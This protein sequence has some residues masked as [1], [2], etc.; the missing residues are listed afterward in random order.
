MVDGVGAD[1]LKGNT[2]D[3]AHSTTFD[4]SFLAKALP[5]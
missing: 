3:G 5:E 2:I 4:G 1:V